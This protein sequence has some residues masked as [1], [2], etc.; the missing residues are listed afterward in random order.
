M[1]PERWRKHW[2]LECRRHERLIRNDE[3]KWNDEREWYDEGLRQQ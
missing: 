3:R 2:R 1:G